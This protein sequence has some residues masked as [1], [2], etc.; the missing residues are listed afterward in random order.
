MQLYTIKGAQ[1]CM[2]MH[3]PCRHQTTNNNRYIN[4]FGGIILVVYNLNLDPYTKY[5]KKNIK[6]NNKCCDET[7]IPKTDN[8]QNCK[9]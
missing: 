5:Q 1:Q 3:L 2:M 4:I 8:K 7:L 9:R 6:E